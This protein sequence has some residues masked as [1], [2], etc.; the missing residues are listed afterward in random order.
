MSKE[1]KRNIRIIQELAFIVSEKS[2]KKV[3]QLTSEII[4]SNIITTSRIS[5]MCVFASLTF[6]GVESETVTTHP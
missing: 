2:S 4:V 1:F 5:C 6:V 3:A